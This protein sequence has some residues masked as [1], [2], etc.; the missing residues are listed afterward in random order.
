MKKGFT[1]TAAAVANIK[2]RMPAVLDTNYIKFVSPETVVL[3]LLCRLSQEI[4]INPYYI[5]L[6]SSL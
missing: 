4:E 6:V 2:K 5:R 3:D 1:W